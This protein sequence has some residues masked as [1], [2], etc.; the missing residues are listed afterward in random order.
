[1][2]VTKLTVKVEK[3]EEKNKAYR[4]AIALTGKMLVI[5]MQQN[6]PITNKNVKSYADQM[7]KLLK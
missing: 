1:M 4:K 3:L 6:K 2:S 5:L 7:N